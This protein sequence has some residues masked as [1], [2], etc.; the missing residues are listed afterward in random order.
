MRVCVCV[1]VRLCVCVC[2]CVWLLLL[3]ACVCVRAC[4]MCMRACVCVSDCSPSGRSFSY[5]SSSQVTPARGDVCTCVRVCVSA[6]LSVC[7]GVPPPPL[8]LSLSLSVAC[9][10][11]AR[12]R[13]RAVHAQH[14]VLHPCWRSH[15]QLRGAM[16]CDK[17]TRNVEEKR[18]TRPESTRRTQ[19]R[20]RNDAINRA[21]PF[22]TL[23][24]KAISPRLRSR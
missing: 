11:H 21:I 10:R 9:W 24:R 7:V 14:R 16:A 23:S 8:S 6:C 18:A 1:C 4:Y 13:G 2:V 15:R 3:C 12:S 17:D 20:Q 22:S 5:S 19:P